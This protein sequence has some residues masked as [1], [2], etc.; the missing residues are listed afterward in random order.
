MLKSVK[1]FELLAPPAPSS[2]VFAKDLN[3]VKSL[4]ARNSPVRTNEQTAIAIFWAGS[5]VPP[6]NAVGRTAAAAWLTSLLD[7]VRLFAYLNL[8]MADAFIAGADA[9]RPGC[10]RTRPRRGGST[11]R[12]APEQGLEQ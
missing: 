10:S 3:E 12:N 11:R 5:E 6:L 9:L 8:A 2:A 4:G 1:Q 7:N